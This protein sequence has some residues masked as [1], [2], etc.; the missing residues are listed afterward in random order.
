M[1]KKMK[2]EERPR[3]RRKTPK[4]IET[5]TKII[6]GA[7]GAL[8]RWGVSA[9]TTRRIAEAA[10][11]N[12]AIIHYHFASKEDLFLALL[13]EL[14]QH[15]KSEVQAT[16]EP[17]D[18][19]EARL[20][21]FIYA[22]WT[23]AQKTERLQLVQLELTLYALKTEG[24]EWVAKRQYETYIDI[25]K[26]MLLDGLSAAETV[27]QSDVD[28]I[29]RFLL[30]GMDGLML[31]VFALEDSDNSRQALEALITTSLAYMADLK[32]RARK[33]KCS[34]SAA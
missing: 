16:L 18:S 2:S 25:Y 22:I 13:D 15:M 4:S 29:A 3:E 10:D 5:R 28:A 21:A 30:R 23:Y 33:D 17:A 6:R 1:T 19:L 7:L 34:G 32:T 9:T 27:A 20:E 31:Q 11:V 26:R 8:D 14:G 24:A 12:L